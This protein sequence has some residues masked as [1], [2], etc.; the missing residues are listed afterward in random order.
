[1]PPRHALTDEQWDRIRDLLPGK[2]GDPG[3]SGRDNRLFVDAVLYVAKTGIPWRDL[4][5]RFGN[6]NSVWRRFDR[7]SDRGVWER[8]ASELGEP[9]LEELQLD[10]T[11]VKVHQTAVGGRRL[12]GEKKRGG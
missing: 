10:S 5:T 4:P 11:S 3:R 7:W 6:W 1:M 2:P 8:I 9:E 12:S